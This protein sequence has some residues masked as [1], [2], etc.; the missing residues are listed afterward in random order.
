MFYQYFNDD[1]NNS[2]TVQILQI[3]MNILVLKSDQIY[4]Q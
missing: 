2:Y 4:R 3:F 1:K